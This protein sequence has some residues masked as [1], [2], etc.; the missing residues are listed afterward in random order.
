[1]ASWNSI[2]ERIRS[3]TMDPRPRPDAGAEQLS[4]MSGMLNNAMRFRE[5]RPELEQRWVDVSYVDLVENPM[6]VVRHIYERLGWRLEPE[7]RNEMEDWLSLQAEQRRGEPRHRYSLEDFGLTPQRVDD[8][9]APYR[10]FI[11]SRGIREF[12]S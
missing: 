6:A 1:M 2:V 10:D 4:I 12:R 3:I 8:A 7:A 11:S 5:S 9:F